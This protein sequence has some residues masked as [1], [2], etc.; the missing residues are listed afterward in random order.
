MRGRVKFSRYVRLNVAD[1][2]KGT[3]KQA[4]GRVQRSRHE[5]Q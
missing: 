5:V 1:V 3:I 4:W 2:G